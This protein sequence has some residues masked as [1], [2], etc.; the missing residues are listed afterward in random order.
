MFIDPLNIVLKRNIYFI[1]FICF[2]SI[3]LLYYIVNATVQYILT[4]LKCIITY[5]TY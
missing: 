5:I 4:Q 2:L 1:S 3:K